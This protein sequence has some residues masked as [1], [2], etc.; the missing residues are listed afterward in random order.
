MLPPQTRNPNYHLSSFSFLLPQ[1]RRFTLPFVRSLQ[2]AAGSTSCAPWSASHLPMHSRSS[3]QR[4]R[5]MNGLSAAA[6][7]MRTAAGCCTAR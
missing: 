1:P 7:S 3:K 6:C 2:L 4:R 5:S